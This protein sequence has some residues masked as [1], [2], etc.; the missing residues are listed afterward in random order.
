[1]KIL[2]TTITNDLKW[3]RN[4][5]EL[6]SKANKRMLLLKKVQSFGATREEMVHLWILY[7]RAILEQS[8][9]LWGSSMTQ[10][11]K[12]DLERIQKSFAK[13]VLKNEYIDY[14]NALLKLN[15]QSLVQRRKELCSNL[16]NNSIKHNTLNDLFPENQ[17]SHAMKTRN[18]EKYQVTYANTESLRT[19][20]IIYMQN[21]LNEEHKLENLK[22]LP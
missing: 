22:M 14:E 18:P 1:M 10:E 13:M 9:T 8:A 4:C 7:C 2:G 17:K 21:L 19:S 20:T 12:D 16:A 11:N 3:A 15:L 6:I 5:D